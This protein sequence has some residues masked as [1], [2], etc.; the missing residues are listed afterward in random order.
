[1]NLI[2]ELYDSLVA[3]E[4]IMWITILYSEAVSNLFYNHADRY[5]KYQTIDF[6]D[7][8]P[9]DEIFIFVRK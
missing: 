7:I 2:D 5:S 4:D 9:L 3:N 1:M 8:K 6:M